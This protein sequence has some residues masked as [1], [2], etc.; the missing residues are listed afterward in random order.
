MGSAN[1]TVAVVVIMVIKAM[2][3][4]AHAIAGGAVVDACH[5]LGKY[6][7]EGGGGCRYLPRQGRETTIMRGRD[8]AE[9][10][11]EGC[12]GFIFRNFYFCKSYKPI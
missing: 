7:I 3:V 2:I 8:T 1:A 11:W 12:L 6:C 5:L 10:W 9:I 4:T